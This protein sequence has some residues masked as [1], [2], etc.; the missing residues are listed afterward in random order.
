MEENWV[1]GMPGLTLGGGTGGF[2]LSQHICLLLFLPLGGCK[3]TS[4][5]LIILQDG[6]SK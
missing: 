2:S 3:I 1:N 5:S 6:M 4:A